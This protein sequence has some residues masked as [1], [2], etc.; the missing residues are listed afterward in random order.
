M[1]PPLPEAARIF[2]EETVNEEFIQVMR[3]AGIADKRTTLR[4]ARNGWAQLAALHLEKNGYGALDLQSQI[5]RLK[6][7]L[8]IPKT[9]LGGK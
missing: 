2:A 9:K 3:D 7:E 4:S 1:P 8:T 5:E 6:K